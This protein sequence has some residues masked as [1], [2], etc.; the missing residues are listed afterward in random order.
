MKLKTFKRFVNESVDRLAQL[1]MA[2]ELEAAKHELRQVMLDLDAPLD[3]DDEELNNMTPP[4]YDYSYDLITGYTE[5]FAEEVF[6]GLSYTQQIEALGQTWVFDE[7]EDA[8]EETLETLAQNQMDYNWDSVFVEVS[9]MITENCEVMVHGVFNSRSGP[10]DDFNSLTE[11]AGYQIEA[12]G[13]SEKWLAEFYRALTEY[14]KT[15]K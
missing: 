11:Q 1:G 7:A 2:S 14:L 15:N 10:D 4:G 5:H 3:V 13:F 12:L 6:G 8:D 9:L